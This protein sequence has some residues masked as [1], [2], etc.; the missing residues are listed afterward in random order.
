MSE[1][2]NIQSRR[3][4]LSRMCFGMGGLAVV[5]FGIP[6]G[7]FVM[8]PLIEKTPEVWREVGKVDDF[9]IGE[10]VQRTFEDASPLPWSGVSAKTACWLRRRSETEFTAFSV[11]CTHLGCP[12]RWLPSAGLFMCPC[13]GGV[14]Y[15]D[16]QVAAGPPPRPLP[17]YRVRIDRDAVQVLASA[18]PIS[19]D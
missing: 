2:N 17:Q 7:I 8:A 12:V 9:K 4:F 19:T 1:E 13:H 6:M 10:T 14:Y 15:D 3:D 16:G 18:V 5:T 11:N